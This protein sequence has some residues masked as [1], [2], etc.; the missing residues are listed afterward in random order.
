MVYK[1][2]THGEIATQLKNYLHQIALQICLY[3]IFLISFDIE[4]PR[5][6]W[7]VPP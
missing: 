7:T 1:S 4:E 6:L 5:P 2:D 3:G